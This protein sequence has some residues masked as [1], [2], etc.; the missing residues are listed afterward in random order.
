V[1]GVFDHALV[2]AGSTIV[3][4]APGLNTFSVVAVDT[5]GNRSAPTTITA[6]LDL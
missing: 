6:D 3:Y 1:N 4:G 5:A 2:A